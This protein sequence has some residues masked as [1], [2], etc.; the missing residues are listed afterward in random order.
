MDLD[1]QPE[2]INLDKMKLGVLWNYALLSSI[3]P[4]DITTKLLKQ[5]WG[6]IF[7]SVFPGIL[8]KLK[9]NGLLG[10]EKKKNSWEISYL[11]EKLIF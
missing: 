4:W 11:S 2:A 10:S 8:S 9:S 5:H 1:F 6:N 3:G 7:A